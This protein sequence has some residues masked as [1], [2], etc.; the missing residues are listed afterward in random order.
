MHANQLH[1]SISFQYLSANILRS[2]APTPQSPTCSF[3]PCCFATKM[4]CQNWTVRFSLKKEAQ[5]ANR[6]ERRAYIDIDVFIRSLVPT[7]IKTPAK[8]KLSNRQILFYTNA[9][10]IEF[11]N[12]L[13]NSAKV[14]V[15]PAKAKQKQKKKKRSQNQLRDLLEFN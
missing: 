7:R 13:R 6:P 5:F 11:V 12:A 4:T 1:R 8:T 15:K 9:I 14:D 2:P 3:I 10:R